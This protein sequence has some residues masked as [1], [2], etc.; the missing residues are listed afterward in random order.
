MPS[1]FV[2]VSAAGDLLISSLSPSDPKTLLKITNADISASRISSSTHISAADI[3]ADSL[4]ISGG[5]S[6]GADLDVD[7]TIRAKGNVIGS[8]SYVDSSDAR[9]KRDVS[10]LTSATQ[11]VNALQAVCN[12]TIF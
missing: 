4:T 1:S 3:S 10:N 2:S 5:L 12:N 7:G 8:G 11:I 9:F 6:V